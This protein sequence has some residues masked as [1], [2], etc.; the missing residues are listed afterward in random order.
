MPPSPATLAIYGMA[1]RLPT[2]FANNS[3]INLSNSIDSLR[4][5]LK[6]GISLNHKRRK[7]LMAKGK[8]SAREPIE[9][10]GSQS[11]KRPVTPQKGG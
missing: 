9:T 3:K 4:N 2:K 6:Q 5:P 7:N 11:F 8:L 10:L 1:E